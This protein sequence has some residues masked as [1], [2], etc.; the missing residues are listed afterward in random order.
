MFDGTIA[1][2]AYDKDNFKPL[3]KASMSSGEKVAGFIDLRTGDF[4]RA[5]LIKNSRD[6]DIFLEKY[7][8]S[9][10]EIKNE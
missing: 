3:I 8:I 1:N 7:E 9:V 6:I 5:M 2:E 4:I 10:A